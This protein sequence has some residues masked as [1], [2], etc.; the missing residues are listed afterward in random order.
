MHKKEQNK[1]N[2]NINRVSSGTCIMICFI[3]GFFFFFFANFIIFWII[4]GEPLLLCCCFKKVMFCFVLL[5][6]RTNQALQLCGDSVTSCP[7]S[8][9]AAIFIKTSSYLEKY[10]SSSCMIYPLLCS[11]QRLLE[12]RRSLLQLLLVNCITACLEFG[13]E[14]KIAV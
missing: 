4:C 12:H 5:P 9:L 8:T 2:Q 13:R 7:E 10:V 3:W 1:I 11:H 14:V 6:K